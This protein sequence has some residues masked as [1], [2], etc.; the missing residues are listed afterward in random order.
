MVTVDWD[1]STG[2]NLT[3]YLSKSAHE[4]PEGADIGVRTFTFVAGRPYKPSNNVAFTILKEGAM[5]WTNH[6]QCLAGL[7]PK[8]SELTQRFLDT[9]NSDECQTA[10]VTKGF[11][12]P[13]SRNVA[14]PGNLKSLEQLMT[15]QEAATK[16]IRY[17]P[18]T[19]GERIPELNQLV[20]R[21]LK[22]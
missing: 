17:D 16:L 5:Q 18:R 19:V 8:A 3:A 6:M 11:F 7:P 14:I 2:A 20:N 1:D 15:A 21:T 12:T 4:C 22:A 10:W 13:V 9:W